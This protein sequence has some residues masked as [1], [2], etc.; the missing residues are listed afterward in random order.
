ML[1]SIHRHSPTGSHPKVNL[2]CGTC[3]AVYLNWK[4][5]SVVG[6][7]FDFEAYNI[8]GFVCYSVFNCAF[9]WSDSIQDAYKADHDGHVNLVKINDVVFALHAVLLTVIT[10]AQIFIYDRGSQR[11]STLAKFLCAVM[12]VSA[13]VYLAVVLEHVHG[14]LWTWLS[15][16][17]YLSYIKLFVT[18]IKYIPQVGDAWVWAWMPWSPTLDAHVTCHVRPGVP[19]V[20]VVLN[21]RRKST[22]GWNVY[23]VILDFMGGF[24]SVMQLMIDSRCVGSSLPTR[25]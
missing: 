13:L 9:F 1:L 8:I 12:V 16:L 17:Y 10:I 24:L 25:G 14:H 21:F 15:F 3:G 22:I 5:K 20:Q 2:P 11:V 18:V 23:N 19:P 4:R 7:S 6:L